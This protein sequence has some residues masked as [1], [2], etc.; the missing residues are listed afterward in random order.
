MYSQ[1]FHGLRGLNARVKRMPCAWRPLLLSLTAAA[2][3]MTFATARADAP[4]VTVEHQPM[5][6]TGLAAS[7]PFEAW[8]VFDKSSDPRVPGYAIPAAL[9]SASF[10]LGSSHHKTISFRGP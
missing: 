4:A 3:L 1:N 7:Q 5:V 9:R 6:S 2:H 10:S 8:F